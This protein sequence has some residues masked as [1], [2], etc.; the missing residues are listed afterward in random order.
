MGLNPTASTASLDGYAIDF[1]DLDSSVALT[2]SLDDATRSGAALTWSV[3]DQPW[4]AGDLIMLRI[5]ASA[6]P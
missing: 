2:L 4:E 3:A 1:I 5:G 6:N